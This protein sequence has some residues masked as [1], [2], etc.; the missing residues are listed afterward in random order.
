MPLKFGAVGLHR[1]TSANA[2]GTPLQ[3]ICMRK[4]VPV[5]DVKICSGGQKLLTQVEQLAI[6]VYTINILKYTNIY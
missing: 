4:G 5:K 6:T 3:V 2:T 1:G